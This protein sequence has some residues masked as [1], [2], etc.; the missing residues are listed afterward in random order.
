MKRIFIIIFMTATI[1]VL[2]QEVQLSTT[3]KAITEMQ[4]E[5]YTKALTLFNKALLSNPK[6]KEAL[7]YRAYTKFKQKDF[8][9]ALSDI[10]K[11]LVLDPLCSEC[12]E[13]RANIKYK[14]N[15]LKGCI[16]DYEKAIE[17]SPNVAN[18][19]NYYLVAKSKLVTK[20]KPSLGAFLPSASFIEKIITT[21]LNTTDFYNQY[22]DN[23]LSFNDED[24]LT[25]NS[26]TKNHDIPRY[27]A[28]LVCNYKGAKIHITLISKTK[29]DPIT[30]VT[31]SVNCICEWFSNWKN[32]QTNGFVENKRIDEN[33]YLEIWGDKQ[34][35]K[36]KYSIY[37]RNIQ[38]RIIMWTE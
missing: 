28:E 15:D 18:G 35:L 4:N 3:D 36:T 32:L 33:G 23:I 17:I 6:D 16:K 10:N 29:N 38:K 37:L 12:L 25:Y 9:S 14:M 11:A 8:S 1:S 2:G 13:I 26:E 19:N 31:V 21:K 7:Q 34:N 24:A 27:T 5:N 22:Y 30:N 20:P